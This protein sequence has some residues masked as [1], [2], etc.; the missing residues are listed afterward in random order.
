MRHRVCTTG[1]TDLMQVKE[2][3]YES[4][5]CKCFQYWPAIEGQSLRFTTIS[6]SASSVGTPGCSGWSGSGATGGPGNSGTM[7]PSKKKALYGLARRSASEVSNSNKFVFEVTHLSSQPGEDYTC[8]KLQ[9][10]DVK[11]V[12]IGFLHYSGYCF[13]RRGFGV[14][15]CLLT[16]SSTTSRPHHTN[17]GLKSL[18]IG[19]CISIGSKALWK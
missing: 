15:G 7:A 5:R 16:S 2:S 11:V 8:T 10:K 12:F 9:L 4:Q 1:A 19:A 3:C 17:N 14:M 13:Q 18:H 6:P